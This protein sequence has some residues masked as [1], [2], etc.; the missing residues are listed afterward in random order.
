ML[1]ARMMYESIQNS[2]LGSSNA[3]SRAYERSPSSDHH[4]RRFGRDAHAIVFF[5]RS[6]CNKIRGQRYNRLLIRCREGYRKRRRR[7]LCQQYPKSSVYISDDPI[8]AM[9]MKEQYTAPPFPL[10]RELP[11]RS[12]APECIPFARW[13]LIQLT[14]C[15]FTCENTLEPGAHA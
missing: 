12:R 14:T 1:T 9:E 3:R 6:L 2:S 11:P 5:A 10:F 13:I 15:R 8:F 7:M 4:H